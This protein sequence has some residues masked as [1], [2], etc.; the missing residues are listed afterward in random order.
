MGVGQQ[1]VFFADPS[2]I[3]FMLKTIECMCKS[4]NFFTE[5]VKLKLGYLEEHLFVLPMSL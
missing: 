4:S 3:L 1:D 5:V 2:E